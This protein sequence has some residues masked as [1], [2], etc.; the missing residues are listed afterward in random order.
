M[1][2]QLLDCRLQGV[3]NAQVTTDP[4]GFGARSVIED[5]GRRR[6][7]HILQVAEDRD[8][9]I[10]KPQ[11]QRSAVF[12]VAQEDKRQDGDGRELFPCRVARQERF[13]GRRRQHLEHCIGVWIPF[14]RM[15]P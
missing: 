12:H 13:R 15:L 2:T 7:S 5:R 11:R 14:R 1:C 10:R 9:C 8:E 4:G 3:P 6:D